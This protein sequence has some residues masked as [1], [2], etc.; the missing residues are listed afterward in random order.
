M[1]GCLVAVLA[2]VA[3][4][5]GIPAAVGA[6]AAWDST[7]AGHVAVVRNGGSF[8]NS[9]IRKIIDPSHGMTWTGIWSTTHKYPS[10]Q[11]SY[12]ITSAA[13]AGD[14]V[15]VDVVQTPSKDGV[16]MGIEGVL[17]F[18]LNLDHKVLRDFDDKFGTRTFT[19]AGKS[20]HPFDGD[21]GWSVF[22][23]QMFRPVIDNDLRQAISGIS[24]ADL[25][26]SCS[27]VQNTTTTAGA[28]APGGNAVNI[29]AIQDAINKS[30]ATDLAA[31]L[32]DQ[33]F[34]GLRFNLV[35]ISLPPNVQD[36]VNNSQAAY[37]QVSEAQAQVVQAKALA[38]ANVARQQ[39]YN[40]CPMCAQID[41]MK[42]IPP[43]VTTFAP[44][45]GTSLSL[46]GAR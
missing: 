7:D 28:A 16:E 27:L 6:A 9:N 21:T 8:S 11:R 13:S 14:R 46:T 17:Y 18:Q 3:V 30:L 1:R 26:S 4:F 36:A 24:C 45:A 42:A 39:G 2:L 40:A 34:T 22:L 25:V 31:T 19:E 20:E 12:T 15:G 38:D 41:L 33:F 43:T 10:Q 44:G 32:G 35:K 5:A 37:A 29:A 23:D